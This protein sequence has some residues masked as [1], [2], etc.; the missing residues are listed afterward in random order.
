MAL[1]VRGRFHEPRSYLLAVGARHEGVSPLS[2]FPSTAVWVWRIAERPVSGALAPTPSS[3][4]GL[5][6]LVPFAALG[7]GGLRWSFTHPAP[8]GISR[9]RASAGQHDPTPPP[10]EL[11]L[12]HAHECQP[13]SPGSL[14]LFGTLPSVVARL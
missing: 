2:P 10:T 9:R 7:P 8:P 11:S 14:D 3:L 12:Y 4:R 6:A 5:V 1:L 13:G